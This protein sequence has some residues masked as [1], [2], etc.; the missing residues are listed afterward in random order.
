MACNSCSSNVNGI[1]FPDFVSN[2]CCNPCCENQAVGGV[3]NG[4]GCHSCGCNQGAVAGTSTGCGCSHNHCG[5]HCNHNHC[6]CNQ[7]TGS[8][9]WENDRT[10]WE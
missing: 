1:I 10:K 2:S 8:C 5:C 7:N 6:G 4:C 3:S 9:I